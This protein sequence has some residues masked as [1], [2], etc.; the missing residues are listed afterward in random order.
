MLRWSVV[1]S[2]GG[3]SL[4]LIKRRSQL[5]SENQLLVAL[6]RRLGKRTAKVYGRALLRKPLYCGTV[7][8]P[9][10]WK[11]SWN[12]YIWK[13]KRESAVEMLFQ[14]DTRS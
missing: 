11:S 7:C 6:G 13:Y 4:D 5:R 3:K 12:C 10:Y 8:N 2:Q 14:S 9:C 1:R